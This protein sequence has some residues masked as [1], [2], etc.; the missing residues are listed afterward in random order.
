MAQRAANDAA[1]D[2]AGTV[3]GGHDPLADEERHRPRMIGHDLVAEPLRLDRL[4]VVA[5]E[6]GQALDDRHEQVGAVV[7][8]D[9]LHDRADAL[10]PHPG[11]DALEGQLGQRPVR[12]TVELHEDEVP[13]LEPARAVL[14]VIR[15]AARS[16]GKVGAPVVVQLAARATGAGV[17][18][19]PEVLLVAGGDIP[20]ADEAL[21][22]QPD[23]VGPYRTRLLVIGVHGGGDAI[24]RDAELI[25]QELPGPVDG[26]ALE[27]IAEAPVAEHLEQRV[28]AGRPPH[29]LEVVVLAL[30]AE[31]E[32]RVHRADVVALLLAGQ[33]ALEGCHA[34]V[35]EQERRVVAR[36]QRRRG[37]AGVAAR[38]EEALVL[39]ADLGRA[40]R[41]H[42]QLGCST[43]ARAGVPTGSRPCC[44]MRPGAAGWRVTRRRLR[45]PPRARTRP[46]S[47]RVPAR[48]RRGPRSPR[49]RRRSAWRRRTHRRAPASG[50]PS[51][52]R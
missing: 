20:P 27:V 2:I 30:D 48:R 1:Q 42:G 33:H 44:V 25:G 37:H 40:L 29:L 6:R 18:H 11:V 24:A 47:P 32:L 22:R 38:L 36:E 28:V 7:R 45:R 23:L 34:R 35:D 46:A 14:G 51:R 3:I 16:F 10:E 4:R 31:A 5:D 26:V 43:T 50:P 19:A 13:D 17:A 12:G 9:A 15:H 49:R 52:G 39:L 21:R 41:F 8:V